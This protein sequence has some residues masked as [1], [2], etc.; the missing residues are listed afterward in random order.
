MFNREIKLKIQKHNIM[1]KLLYFLRS[2][3]LLGIFLLATSSVVIG[4]TPSIKVIQPNG[5]EQWVV[6]TAHLI[7]WTDNLTKPVMIILTTQGGT[8]DTLTH[9]VSG[10]IWAW[11]IPASQDTSSKC[12]IKIVS[13]T[14]TSISATSDAFFSL[15]ATQ[16]ADSNAI[17]Q[18]NGGEKW[19]VGTSHL[20]SWTNYVSKTA[21]RLSIDGGAHYTTL[22]GADSISGSTFTWDIPTSQT[23]SDSCLIKV[24]SIH[25]TSVNAVSDSLFS[26]VATSASGA[27][28]LLQPTDAGIHWKVGTEHLVSWSDN[29]QDSVKVVLM[30]KDSV[31][32]VLSTNA[33]GSGYAWTIAD[34][35]P[36]DTNYR[37]TVSNTLDS[38]IADTSAH[39]FAIDSISSSDTTAPAK[40]VTLV[41]PNG[42]ENWAVKTSHLISWYD[43]FSSPVKIELMHGGAFHSVVVSSV[44]GNG[45]AWTIPD[46]ITA[47]TSYKIKVL[48]TS[49]TTII[50]TSNASFSI[51]ATPLGGT[52]K[53]IQPNGGEKWALKTIH[54][55]SWTDNFTDPVM[56]K[57]Y[58]ADTLYAVLDSS[59][60]DNRYTWTISD[61]I[62]IDTSYKIKVFN[63][64]DTSIND[65]SDAS[66][67]IIAH[68]LGQTTTLVQPNGGEQWAVNE[69]H[70]ISWTD[71]F[72]D[73]I[74]VELIHAD[75]L[76]SVLDSSNTDNRYVWSIPDSLPI[77]SSYK[78]KIIST[79]DPSIADSSDTTFAILAHPLGQSI[80]LVQPNGGEEWA[81]GEAHLISWLEN[82][83]DPVKVELYHSDTLYSVLDSSNTDNRFTWTVPDSIPIDSSYRVKVINTAD[84][85]IWDRSDTTF[86]VLAHP[87][88]QH[89]TLVQPNGG[90]Q[91]AY[92]Q[93][94]LIS[95]Y[96]NFT[97]PVKVELYHSDTLYSVLDSSNTDNRYTWTIPDSLPVD[98]SYRVKVI[99]TADTSIWDRS[100][101]TFAVLKYP[102]N[103]HITLVQPNG[104]EK[105]A[106]H[107]EH[108]ISWYSNFTYPVRVELYNADTLYSVLDSSV[109]NNRY[110]WTVPDSL[111]IDTSYRIK[112]IDTVDTSVWDRSDT[113]FS[114]VAFVPGGEIKVIQPN[115][116][117]IK[118]ARGTEHLVSW[119]DNLSEAVNVDLINTTDTAVRVIAH[120][121]T[122]ST[123]SWLIPD[124]LALKDNYKVRISSTLQPVSDESDTTFSVVAYI[125]GGTVNVIQPN[126]GEKWTL[127]TAH[128]I[129]WTDNLTESVNIYLIDTTGTVVPDTS[130][131]A[132]SVDGS[133][134]AWT[135]SD[136][137]PVGSGYKVK[138][139][140]SLQNTISDVSDSTFSLTKYASNE[141][142]TVQ[143]PN[144]G[145]Y[146]TPGSAN[147][148]SWSSNF[149]DTAKIELYRANVLYAVLDSMVTENRYTWT[150]S[151]TIPY[152]STYKIKVL[153][154][155]DTTVFDESDTTFS[156][157]NTPPG[158][159]ITVQQPNGGETYT[160]GSGVLISW[161]GNLTQLNGDKYNILLEHYDG[162]GV[163]D[164]VDTIVKNVV[165]SAYTWNIPTNQT[166]DTAYRIKITGH[167]LTGVA[168]SSDRNF[169]IAAPTKISAYPNP[170]TNFVTVKVN[171]NYNQ[172]YVVSLYN[173]YGVKVL[174]TNLNTS[175]S[176]EVRLSTIG[177]PNGVYFVTLTSGRERIAKI[178]IIQH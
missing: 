114:V 86:A 82:F 42:G 157:T 153:N 139:A 75:T 178:I 136:T 61:S 96:E 13:T 68:P 45:F 32:S 64:A 93:S 38:A 137:L 26:I 12:M 34:S 66:F 175:I 152:D 11:N 173:R 55:I 50:D 154:M 84:T 140:S 156:I 126:R 79:V 135:I 129:S 70:L 119:T 14:N 105:W 1:K 102:L 143:Q 166:A 124:T 130:L 99:N 8:D 158:G 52:I 56:V 147:L 134:Y 104:G 28:T 110:T 35:I 106:S 149:V 159:Q 85:S 27:I 164:I 43:N 10:T 30:H 78:V 69:Q 23:L 57:L 161:S 17:I 73:P 71:N 150:I 74:K 19:A 89:I 125:P 127:G 107:T 98:T 7:S 20:I 81:V 59:A 77:D 22:P 88:N 18:P 115:L 118:W 116:V 133:T 117:G 15:K 172:N 174:T 63:T 16:P 39:Y 29:F 103:Q 80:T 131:I 165:P 100:D 169:T 41:Q 24:E 2:S 92:G 33:Y 145:E 3:L 54:L 163:L 60:T 44:S 58:H 83:T 138:V 176:K 97:T 94:H 4:Q 128:L 162:T 47:D 151:D 155:A 90:D 72:T 109:T 132:S 95:W 46:T 53:V 141:T 113:T 48:N 101:T 148:I 160:Q 40:T 25:D 120:N 111:P 112:V 122:G 65:S 91:W 142:I 49:D 146:W 36:G 123:Y 67:K 6:G 37:I 171:N 168:D 167:I 31:Y 108:L 170:T 21:I 9:S 76:Y 121:V 5:G 62:P 87:L 144:G 51:L 177:M